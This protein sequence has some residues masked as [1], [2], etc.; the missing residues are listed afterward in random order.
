MKIESAFFGEQGLTSTS[1]NYIANLCKEKCEEWIAFI[2]NLVLYTTKVSLIGTSDKSIVQVGTSDLTKVP[3]YLDNIAKTKSLIAWLREAIKKK[4]EF[5]NNLETEKRNKVTELFP[6]YPVKEHV[7]TEEEYYDSL[8]IKERNRYY[9][10]ET[11]A[12]IIGKAIHPNGPFNKARK[13]L[14]YII[15]NPNKV[16]GSGRDTVIYTYTPTV[17]EENV[18]DLF[19]EL[20]SKHRSI[21]TELNSIKN[22]C[23]EVIKQETLR[24]QNKFNIDLDNYRVAVEKIN[25]ELDK[26]YDEKINYVNKLKIVIPNDLKLIYEEIQKLG[27]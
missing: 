21:Q 22:K 17:S 18:N 15:N 16:E 1:A 3:E 11:E 24:V 8:P 6:K 14:S 12:A 9:S 23:Q 10:L 2:N 27:K 26:E 7:L 19:F 25:N 4:E 13:N 20:Q 5:V